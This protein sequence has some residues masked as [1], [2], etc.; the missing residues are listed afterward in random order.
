MY[1]CS[2][3]RGDHTEVVEVEFNPSKTNFGELLKVFYSD[4]DPTEPEKAQ[5]MSA[6]YYHDDEQRQLAES[7]LQAEQKNRDKKIVT[8]ILPAGKF[9]DAEE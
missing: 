1:H 5:Y 2:L 8:K 3:W 4:H 9:Y 6:I 7:S